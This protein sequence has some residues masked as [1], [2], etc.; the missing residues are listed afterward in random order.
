MTDYDDHNCI[1]GKV[2]HFA[3]MR[4]C[5][6]N[7]VVKGS[8][9]LPLRAIINLKFHKITKDICSHREVLML[10]IFLNKTC[11]VAIMGSDVALFKICVANDTQCNE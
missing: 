7:F 8:L 3:I 2:H 11:H 10:S 4:G 9:G 1:C 6:V 5:P